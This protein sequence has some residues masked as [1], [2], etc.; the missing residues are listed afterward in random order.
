MSVIRLRHV[1]TGL[2]AVSC[3]FA[4][5]AAGAVSGELAG[6]Q[7]A[8]TEQSKFS[9]GILWKIDVK[10]MAPNYLFGTMHSDDDRVLKLPPVV[11]QAFEGARGYGA[12][13]VDDE[14]SA[15]KFY[16]A[17]VTREPAL[18]EQLGEAIYAKV[19]RLLA[20]YGIP[21]EA[22][23]RFKAWAAIITLT[24]PRGAT[25]LILDRVLISEALKRNKPIYPLETIDEQIAAFNGMPAET[26]TVLLTRVVED[27]D[28]IQD[29]IRS[30]TEAYL[31]RD[32]AA[33]WKLNA[34]G[35]GDDA[36]TRPH[37]EIFLQRVLFD[38]NVHMADRLVPLLGKGGV[39]AAFG[40]LH[41]YGDRGV[42]SLLEQ[43]GFEVQRVY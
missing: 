40:A 4:G 31:D 22:R 2:I 7:V 20:D 38:R 14:S 35:M 21:R 27:H 42:L 30:L 3:L 29:A 28:N 24:Q 18:P 16:G 6:S 26:Q 5:F 13:L 37:N 11:A 33:M 12:E 1:L 39:F 8:G 32:L 17:M 9:H 34:E 10:G 43:R 41:L 23:P 25:G 36:V 19:D 15:R